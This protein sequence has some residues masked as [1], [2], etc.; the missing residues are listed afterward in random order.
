MAKEK[1]FEITVEADTNDADYVTKISRI[2]ETDLKKIKPLIQAI[3]NFKP[4]K[5]TTPDKKDGCGRMSWTHDHNYPYGSGE[6]SPR[7][8]LGEK[9]GREIY[10]FP[11][12]IFD[13]FEE[14]LPYGEHGIHTIESIVVTPYVRKTKLL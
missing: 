1:Q 13:L 14:L 9:P 4:Y 2:S 8:D 7:L 11:E 3:K 6:Y 12:T 10:K 5:A